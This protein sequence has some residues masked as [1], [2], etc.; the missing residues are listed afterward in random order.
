MQQLVQDLRT[1][2]VEVVALPDPTPGPGD[3]LVRTA[4]SLIPPGTEQALPRTAGRSLVGKALERPDQARKVIDKA[5]RDGVGPAL[6]AVR[7]R[8]DDLM[9]PGY[10][11][12]GTVAAVGPRVQ[13]PRVGD[14]VG[15]VR[16]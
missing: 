10:S 6:D 9:T 11:S 4:W 13:A 3:V 2:K 12:A 7:A 16:A 5:L 14:R 1:G 15:C 8:L